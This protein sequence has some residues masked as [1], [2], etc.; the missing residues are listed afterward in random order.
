M[1]ELPEVEE[2][3]RYADSTCLHKRITSFEIRAKEMVI[4]ETAGRLESIA[5]GSCFETTRRHGKY[6]FIS[7][8]KE[9]W[10]IL[11]FGMSGRL[12]Y[13]KLG[14]KEPS[15]TRLM[16]Q[17][18]NGY[19]LAFDC[20]RKL[21]KIGFTEVPDSFIE[22]KGLGPD[23]LSIDRGEWRKRMKGRRG[24]VKSAIMNQSIVAGI[25]NEYSDEILYQSRI[26]PESK[27]NELSE[28]EID[29]IFDNMRKILGDVI[30]LRADWSRLPD[31]YLI[32]R[33]KEG[34]DCPNCEG[35]V[36]RI[37]VSGRS[38][39]YCPKCQNKG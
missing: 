9:G 28:D 31:Y 25:G 37:K 4:E 7:L 29:L 19:N 36:R 12:V 33:R 21:G 26:H 13:F 34:A 17:F 3:K 24:M 6:L 30:D 11:H 22:K 27:V 20:P 39:Y 32:P 2:F 10:L 8:N 14:K 15:H 35:K 38:A 5:I 16:V 18:E 1:P 23:A